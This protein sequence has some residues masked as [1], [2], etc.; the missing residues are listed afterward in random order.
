MK[1]IEK[2]GTEAELTKPIADKLN[3]VWAE[4]VGPEWAASWWKGLPDCFGNIDGVGELNNVPQNPNCVQYGV[5][6]WLYGICKAWDFHS[7]AR[8]RYGMLTG[9]SKSMKKS[10]ADGKTN[11]EWVLTMMGDFGAL[12]TCRPRCFGWLTSLFFQTRTHMRKHGP[13]L[14]IYCI[15]REVV[16]RQG[17]QIKK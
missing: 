17:W 7:Y 11:E 15:R 5:I 12:S 16:D 10:T 13:I 3:A 4:A 8:G 6:C 1:S 14:T 2:Y 9:N